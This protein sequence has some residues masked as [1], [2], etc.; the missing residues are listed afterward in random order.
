MIMSIEVII[1]TRII[2]K[3]KADEIVLP[4]LTGQIG[5]LNGHAALIT[6]L[7]TGLL[8]I[9]LN[10]KWTPIILCG[11]LAEIDQDHITVLA[12]D[13]EELDNIKL[14][15]ATQK[16][17]NITASI[18]NAKTSKERLDAS[19]ELKKA[20]ARVEGVNYLSRSR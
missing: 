11:G 15:E 4:G 16:L 19:T 12:N 5:V 20:M 2:C 3:I 8:R 9:K 13:V 6:G 17:E 14:D 1:P 10:E 7:D 18:E